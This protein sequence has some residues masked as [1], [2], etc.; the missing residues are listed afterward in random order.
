L[1]AGPINFAHTLTGLTPAQKRRRLAPP[2]GSFGHFFT[3][4]R[5][6]L[7]Y[8]FW[9]PAKLPQPKTK[10]T[11]FI[12][13]GRREFIEKYFET[14]ADLLDKR[15]AVAVLDWRYQGGSGRPLPNPNKNH[16]NDFGILSDD[17][18]QFLDEAEKRNMPKPWVVLAHSLGAHLFLRF[19]AEHPDQEVRL[20]RAVI[21]APM[22]GINFAPLPIPLVKWLIER[23]RKKGKITAYAPFQG[24]Y[25]KLYQDDKAFDKIT[26]D[27]ERFEDEAW[28]LMK[29]PALAVGGA[30]YGWI[31]AAIRSMEKMK[32][33]E[34][35]KHIYLPLCFVIPGKDRVV[36]NKATEAFIKNL[37]AATSVRL[38]GA[39]HELLKEADDYRNTFLNI[40]E[41]FA[42]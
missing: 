35:A 16:A 2:G 38:Q 25:G 29:T 17:L 32:N 10:G 12:L 22:M 26:S 33:P 37:P 7:R 24:D 27:R 6:R 13:P 14:V 36:D 15:Y 39:R 5:N 4:D 8:G 1:G 21:S 42:K 18:E 30:T 40:F 9:P 28:L 20:E 34:M 19:L 23:A 41:H 31:D 11:V 3:R